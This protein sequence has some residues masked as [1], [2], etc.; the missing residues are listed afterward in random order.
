M[1]GEENVSPM[2][3]Q[4][5]IANGRLGGDEDALMDYP[6]YIR[7]SFGWIGVYGDDPYGYAKTP[8]AEEVILVL[9]HLLG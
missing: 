3:I 9:Y 5:I 8:E 2:K 4:E 7:R 6:L 1:K